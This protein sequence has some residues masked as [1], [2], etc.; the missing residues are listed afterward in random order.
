MKRMDLK[1][2]LLFGLAAL[3]L[4]TWPRTVVGELTKDRDKELYLIDDAVFY[5]VENPGTPDPEDEDVVTVIGVG[6]VSEE[7]EEE[8]YLIDADNLKLRIEN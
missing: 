8:L 1:I 3:A 7:Q 4:A 6:G 2:V 5:T